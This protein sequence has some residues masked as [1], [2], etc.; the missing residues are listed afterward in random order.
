LLII[1]LWRIKQL[2]QFEF[3][4]QLVVKKLIKLRRIRE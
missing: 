2:F 3:E 1:R 4:Q